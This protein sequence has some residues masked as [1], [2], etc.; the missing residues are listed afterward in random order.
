MDNNVAMIYWLVQLIGR[1]EKVTLIAP[2][3]W[4]TG[5]LAGIC[6]NVQ[7]YIMDCDD[8]NDNENN[9]KNDNNKSL[10][11]VWQLAMYKHCKKKL[12]QKYT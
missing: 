6:G 10:S 1:R 7:K 9:N 11:H 3:G 4:T 12:I 2:S 8:N 5:P